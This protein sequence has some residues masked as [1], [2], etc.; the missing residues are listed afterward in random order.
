MSI[1]QFGFLVQAALFA[2][3]VSARFLLEKKADAKLAIFLLY[4]SILLGFVT[5]FYRIHLEFMDRKSSLQLFAA[6]YSMGT[7][8]V[9]IVA[10]AVLAHDISRWKRQKRMRDLRG[11]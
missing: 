9:T 2:I 10:I 11:E 4:A 1:L 5:G 8:L 6:P 7:D 3:H